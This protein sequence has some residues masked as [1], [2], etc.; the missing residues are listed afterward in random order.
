MQTRPRKSRFRPHK[1]LAQ[2]SAETRSLLLDAT[3]ESLAD[4]GYCE[5]T[6]TDVVLRA[7]LTRGAQVHHFPRKTEMVQASAVHLARR[8]REEL[9][10]QAAQLTPG[11]NKA[12]AAVSLLWSTY[13]GPLFWAALELIVAGR[14][15]PE[16]RP[17][18]SSLHDE[19]ERTVHEFC[20]D[21]F[22]AS[23]EG[24]HALYDAVD[25]SIRFMDGLALAGIVKDGAWR[26][27]LLEKWRKLVGPLFEEVERSLTQSP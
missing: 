24:N 19:V 26:A 20:K 4:Q 17:A 18:L 9:H 15:D 22:G 25:L 5:T 12:D 14:T 2:R 10:R 16:L 13:T 11:H 7:G 1:T 23:A 8:V 27:H 21:L 6:T 3:I